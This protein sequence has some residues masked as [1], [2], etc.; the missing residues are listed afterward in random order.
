M[1]KKYRIKKNKEYKNLYKRSKRY[2]NRDFILLKAKS[3]NNYPRFGFVITKKFGKANKRNKI[4]RRIK[5]II[6]YNLNVFEKNTD[7]IFTPK[8]HAIDLDYSKLES[9]LKHIVELSKKI[10]WIN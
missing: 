5:E 2:Y 8:Y 6:R 1:Q 9:S 10:Q 4:R 3:T 7:Y